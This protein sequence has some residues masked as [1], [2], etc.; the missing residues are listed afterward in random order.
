MLMTG[1]TAIAALAA[2]P[3]AAAGSAG[4]RAAPIRS[5]AVP[6]RGFLPARVVVRPGAR[7]FFRNADRLLHTATAVTL[8]RGRPA[9]SSGAPTRGAFSVI[10]PRRPGAYRY[11]CVVHGFMQGVLVV[12]R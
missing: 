3:A 10:A 5:E 6:D 11:I 9:F 2:G 4:S 12:R 1:A 8:V 7:V